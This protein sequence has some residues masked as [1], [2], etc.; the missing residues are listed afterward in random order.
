MLAF[1]LH[2][3]NMHSLSHVLLELCAK[4]DP[5]LIVDRVD[6]CVSHSLLQQPAVCVV[7]GR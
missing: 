5:A 3:C 6:M 4:P 1:V 2:I 7:L